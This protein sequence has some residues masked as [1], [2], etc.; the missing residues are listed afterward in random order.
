MADLTATAAPREGDGASR[1]GTAAKPPRGRRGSGAGGAPALFLL[2]FLIPFTLFYVLPIVYAL[3]RSLHKI[4]RTGGIYGK[5]QEVFSGVSQYS[6]VLASQDFR[7]SVLRVLGFGIVQIPV[8]ML[9]ALGLALLLDSTVARMVRFFRIS[10][11]IPYAIPGVI[12]A[13][14]WGIIYSPGLSPIVGLLNKV[15]LEPQFLSGHWILWSIANVV[16]WT[17]AGYN[18]LIIYSALQAIPLELY[19]AARLDGASNIAIAR[20]IKIPAVAPAIV[21]TG[22]FSIIGTLQLFTEPVVFGKIATTITSTYT[23]NMVVLNASQNN[24]DYAA[25]LSVTLAVSTFILSFAFLKATQRRAT[26]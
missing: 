11:F 16:T 18:M 14:I 5:P 1:S 9:V 6:Q 21:L 13:L 22:V 19:E 12:A 20:H 24:Y 4:Q 23:P 7:S 25:A 10:F 8:M 26:P 17:Y 15:S 3:W 2:P